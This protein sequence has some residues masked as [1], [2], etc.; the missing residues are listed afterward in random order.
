MPFYNIGKLQ[1]YEY[2]LC[3]ETYKNKLKFLFKTLYNTKQ[4][5]K[6]L[7]LRKM[8]ELQRTNALASWQNQPEK[9]IKQKI[10]IRKIKMRVQ[11]RVL[12]KKNMVDKSSHKHKCPVYLCKFSHPEEDGLV[13]HYNAEHEELVELGLKL[14]KSKETR[15]TEKQKKMHEEANKIYL[16]TEKDDAD[17]KKNKS[18]ESFSEM[19]GEDELDIFGEYNDND[20]ELEELMQLEKIEI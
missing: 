18:E 11:N 14:V 13:T 7:D 9:I 17:D 12:R 16:N 4:I 5:K 2:F 3:Q 6:T 15:D 1:G 8:A 20:S 19:S 10:N